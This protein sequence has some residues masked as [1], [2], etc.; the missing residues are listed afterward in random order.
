MN[1][2][3]SL[4]EV[5]DLLNIAPLRAMYGSGVGTPEFCLTHH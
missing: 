1:D 5:E 4:G 2:S 3:A